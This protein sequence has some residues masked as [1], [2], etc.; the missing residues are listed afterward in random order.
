MSKNGSA[1]PPPATTT[2]T[3]T[4]HP[5]TNPQRATPVLQPLPRPPLPATNTHRSNAQRLLLPSICWHTHHELYM[6]LHR[7]PPALT[8][9]RTHNKTTNPP[10]ASRLRLYDF[11]L[12]TKSLQPTSIT[13]SFMVRGN[14]ILRSG[15]ADLSIPWAWAVGINCLS[16][17]AAFPGILMGAPG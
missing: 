8:D 1:P 13:A 5:N 14:K 12:A 4:G 9:T 7:P 6:I 3:T 2:T 15:I 16:G 10:Q 11:C 17:P